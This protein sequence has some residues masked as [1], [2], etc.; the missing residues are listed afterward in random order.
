MCFV[1]A[2][3]PAFA[4]DIVG[5][6][7]NDCTV[8]G[9]QLQGLEPD[10]ARA[11]IASVTP[12][13]G[14]A[15]ITVRAAGRTFTFSTRTALAVDVDAMLQRAYETTSAV[16]FEIAPAYAVKGQVISAWVASRAPGLVKKAANA[17]Y[18][19][20]NGRLGVSPPVNGHR[21]NQTGARNALQSAV[22]KAARG[23][24]PG[25]VTLPLTT[26]PPKITR[27]GLP[28]AIHV[29][30]SQ[31]KIR[32]YFKGRMIKRYRCAVGAPGFSTPRGTF[33]ITAKR[34]NPTWG[35]PG[36]DWARDMPAFIGP[37]PT[38]PLGTR[39]LNLSAPGIR[40]HGTSKRYSIGTAASHG[41]VR[42]L[43]EDV[44]DLFGRVSVG[45][46]VY[47]VK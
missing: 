8:G 37:G 28:K 44:E 22:A 41:C 34:K 10:A 35:N 45:T 17:R 15:P 1:L 23:Q 21:L 33:T 20:R 2:A 16:G 14:A 13:P 25:T 24:A 43:R 18:V 36:S 27:G 4:V 7:P 26:V 9:Q 40:I 47:I 29:D 38:N 31:R 12:Q 11:L 5:P 3:T 32:L 6:V 42:M 30:L 39:A 19:P 46:K